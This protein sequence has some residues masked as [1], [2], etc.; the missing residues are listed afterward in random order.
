MVVLLYVCN[1]IISCQFYIMYDIG[2]GDIRRFIIMVSCA[3]RQGIK[4]MLII[5]FLKINNNNKKKR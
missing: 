2:N 3:S 5:G 4:L 1:K